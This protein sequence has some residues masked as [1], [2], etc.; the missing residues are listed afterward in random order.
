M[1]FLLFTYYAPMAAHGEVAVGERRM[2]WD[3]PSRSAILGLVAAALGIDRSDEEQHLRLDATLW[4]AVRTDAGGRPFTDYQTTQVPGTRRNT[5]FATRREELAADDLNTILSVREWR[6]DALYTVVLWRRLENGVTL[7]SIAAALKAPAFT[8]YGGRRAGPFGWPLS[9][10]LVEAAD[11]VAALRGDPMGQD[12]LLD[13]WLGRLCHQPAHR[14]LAFDADAIGHGAPEPNMIVVRRDRLVSR[15]RWQF[16][17]R[18][19]GLC[20]QG[21]TAE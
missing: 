20:H 14:P 3:R 16:A 1:Q 10:R 12:E 7:E 2:G 15:Q 8:L 6:T 4:Y 9:P 17:E 19:E 18:R 11:L 5:R 21:E 13:T